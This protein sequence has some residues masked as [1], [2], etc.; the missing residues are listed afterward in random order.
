MS[1]SSEEVCPRCNGG[2]LE[3]GFCRDCGAMLDGKRS[4]RV[5][6][7]VGGGFYVFYG[8]FIIYGTLVLP[9]LPLTYLAGPLLVG[10][11]GL[12]FLPPGLRY[13]RREFKPVGR[14]WLVAAWMIVFLLENVRVAYQYPF[15]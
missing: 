10:L 12:A 13:I 4:Y 6:A 5:L 15:L 9:E 11:V 7:W 2:V 3:G 1:S 14:W 8:V